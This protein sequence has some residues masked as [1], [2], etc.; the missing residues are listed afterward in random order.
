MTVEDMAL[1]TFCLLYSRLLG[2]DYLWIV[3]RL[4]PGTGDH[5]AQIHLCLSSLA[6]DRPCSPQLGGTAA[7]LGWC[8]SGPHYGDSETMASTDL[9][10]WEFRRVEPCHFYYLHFC[11]LELQGR[12]VGPHCFLPSSLRSCWGSETIVSTGQ[13]D[14]ECERAAPSPPQILE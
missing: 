12:Q 3:L 5:E 14:W 4:L 7:D 1:Q 9:V 11:F 13:P 2:G 10:G 6:E 8:T